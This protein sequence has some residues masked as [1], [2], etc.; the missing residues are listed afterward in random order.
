MAVDAGDEFSNWIYQIT[1]NTA[2]SLVQEARYRSRSQRW[3]G[4][5]H[6][7]DAQHARIDRNAQKGPQPRT[8]ALHDSGRFTTR[9]SRESVAEQYAEAFEKMGVA[10]PEAAEDAVWYSEFLSAYSQALNGGVSLYN[11]EHDASDREKLY[12]AIFTGHAEDGDIITE[13][14]MQGPNSAYDDALAI[15]QKAAIAAALTMRDQEIS[16]EIKGI[17]AEEILTAAKTIG[18]HQKDQLGDD[19]Y[20]QLI[21]QA[22]FAEQPDG[23]LAASVRPCDAE[24]MTTAV[25][26][27]AAVKLQEKASLIDL[28]PQ[29]LEAALDA[30][31]LREVGQEQV[32]QREKA[33][34]SVRDKGIEKEPMPEYL[35]LDRLVSKHE[36]AAD[37]SA[38]RLDA[39]NGI[40]PD[41]PELKDMP[42]NELIERLKQEEEVQRKEYED[43]I[44]EATEYLGVDEKTLRSSL[45][46]VHRAQEDMRI[47]SSK[48]AVAEARKEKADASFDEAK[49]GLGSGEEKAL[50]ALNDA[51]NKKAHAETAVS[52]LQVEVDESRKRLEAALGKAKAIYTQGRDAGEPGDREP[53][54]APDDASGARGVAHDAVM[55]RSGSKKNVTVAQVWCKASEREAILQQLK[56]IGVKPKETDRGEVEISKEG[57][58]MD[59]SSFEAAEYVTEKG[60]VGQEETE[61]MPRTGREER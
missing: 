54:R 60:H 40:S 10:K 8:E 56:Q 61:R 29:E 23:S 37:A 30:G 43:R 39:E 51:A 2:R 53:V 47:A 26:A 14:Q 45:G 38:K 44:R 13:V 17:D 33:P 3:A 1:S 32:Q 4:Q 27:A 6:A 20:G 21:E 24:L 55:V 28:T 15:R 59:A 31:A 57:A 52:I 41:T 22:A 18:N 9:D 5:D 7:S 48:L 49:K 11:L 12:T 16:Y 19:V 34:M 36:R 42:Q 46:D 58:Q 50:H 25:G 35:S